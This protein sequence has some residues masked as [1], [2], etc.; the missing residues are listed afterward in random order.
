MP[1]AL[2]SPIKSLLGYCPS[3]HH[4]RVITGLGAVVP[5][6]PACGLNLARAEKADGPAVFLIFLLGFII[7][8]AAVV[9]GMNTDWPLWLHALVWGAVVV[10]CTLALQMPSKSLLLHLQYRNKPEDFK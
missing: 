7:A 1:A 6:C 8:P 10:A 4:A 5:R 3:C 9:V 2:L